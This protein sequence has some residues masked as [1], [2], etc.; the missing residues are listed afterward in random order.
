MTAPI[1]LVK[2]GGSLIT[3]KRRRNA[4]RP[5]VIA[6]LSAEA[7]RARAG[8]PAIL[9]HGS[10]SFGHVAAARSGA[11]LGLGGRAGRDGAVETQ[12]A[13]RLLH[14][15]VLDALRAAGARPF[16]F[17]PG[18]F[19]YARAGKPAAAFVDP[20]LEALDRGFLPVVYGDVVLDASRGVAIVSTEGVF[21]AIV[22]A[23]ARR[24]RRVGRAVWLGETAGVRDAAGRTIPSI[25]PRS[26]PAVRRFVGGADGTD[27]TG[28]M[29]LRVETALRLARRGVVSWIADGR[30]PGVLRR[31]LSG[32]D[33]AGTRIASR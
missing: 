28:G 30:T 8:L 21:E 27:V 15:R 5:A 16:S 18:S 12:A 17:A 20:I 33:L 11:H 23:A 31:A 24:G 7:A 32:D 22:A 26:W 29:R 1:V 13:A 3:D 19:L 9:G 10:G 14:E 4:A 2:L 6:R 25:T